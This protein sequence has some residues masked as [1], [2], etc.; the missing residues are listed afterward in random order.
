MQ[1]LFYQER[2]TLFVFLNIPRA[3]EIIWTEKFLSEFIIFSEFEKIQNPD[4]YNKY[5]MINTKEFESDHFDY[6][7]TLNY[8]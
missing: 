1:R 5:L 7:L 4:Y 3:L 8:C 6:Y 2:Q